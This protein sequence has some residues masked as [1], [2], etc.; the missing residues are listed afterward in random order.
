MEKFLDR[1]IAHLLGQGLKNVCLGELARKGVSQCITNGLI[2]LRPGSQQKTAKHP[3]LNFSSVGCVVAWLLAWDVLCH[4]VT[5]MN[6]SE[7]DEYFGTK[8]FVN[9]P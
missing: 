9:D 4:S 6:I 2:G 8:P 3:I 7:L 1:G 5:W